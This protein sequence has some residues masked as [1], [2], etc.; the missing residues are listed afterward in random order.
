MLNALVLICFAV[1]AFSEH[2]Q[3]LNYKNDD[4]SERFT[5]VFMVG[6]YLQAAIFINQ[7]YVDPYFQLLKV[8]R[9]NQNQNPVPFN[10]RKN[11]DSITT[12]SRMLSTSRAGLLPLAIV[13]H[14]LSTCLEWVMHLAAVSLSVLMLA[15]LKAKDGEVCHG[16][17]AGKLGVEGNWLQMLAFV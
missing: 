4:V 6:F 13:V 3:C 17:G 5:L 7:T 10:Y 1:Q 14:S 15:V 11:N 12:T 9:S 2:N 8:F 16:E